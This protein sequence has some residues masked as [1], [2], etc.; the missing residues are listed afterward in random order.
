MQLDGGRQVRA[1]RTPTHAVETRS[2]RR[3][4]P[5][6]KE[7]EYATCSIRRAVLTLTD[8]Q[9]S[10]VRYCYG[11]DL[12][13]S[14]QVAIC[15]YVWAGHQL[16]IGKMQKKTKLR[17]LSLVWITAQDAAARKRNETYKE[18]AGAALAGLMSISRSTWCELYAGHWAKLKDAFE[19]L[20]VAALET[21]SARHIN[22]D[23]EED[24]DE[25]L[26]NRTF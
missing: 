26:H 6:L 10:W 19:A 15:E 13:Y 22:H 17:I 11:N 23:F 16:H 18:Y 8:S 7:L 3:P 14:H 24:G 1:E 5:S 20:D 2:R 21:I 25:I 9:K 12:A 4:A